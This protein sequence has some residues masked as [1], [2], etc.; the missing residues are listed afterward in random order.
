MIILN[1]KSAQIDR[2]AGEPALD[3]SRLNLEWIKNRFAHP[4][5]WQVEVTDE[6]RFNPNH[7]FQPA[8]VLIA[9]V[10]R[11]SGLNVLFTRRTAHLSHHAGQISFP[12]G[13]EE[14]VDRD[15]IQT[16][17]REAQEEIALDQA[18][19]AVLGQLPVYHTVTGY[20]VTPVI[21]AISGTEVLIADKNEVAEIFEVPLQFLMDGSAHQVR[22]ADITLPDQT[23]I[24]RTFYAMPYNDYFIWGVTAGM[25]RNLYH[26]L[27]A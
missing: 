20:V 6:Q 17:L 21:G 16:A 25:L 12:G 13:R 23:T 7:E 15:A 27:R 8:S 22:S 18:R 3:Q 5:P 1:P 26:F 9:L 2:V 11:P 14:A 4:R 10:Q 19:V 24:R